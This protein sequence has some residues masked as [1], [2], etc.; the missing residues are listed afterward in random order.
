MKLYIWFNPYQP[1]YGGSAL[2]VVAK[3]VT[4]ARSLAGKESVRRPFGIG[5]ES[6]A[7]WIDSKKL[8]EPDVVRDLPCA[9]LYEWSE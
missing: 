9:E 1:N 6:G 8:G 3:S 7:N 2:Y 5:S 4:Q